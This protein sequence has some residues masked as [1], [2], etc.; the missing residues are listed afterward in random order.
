[1]KIMHWAVFLSILAMIIAGCGCT[2]TAPAQNTP[3]PAP[4][5]TTPV[6]SPPVPQPTLYPGAL[7][8]GTSVPF[9]IN[10]MNG[11]ATVYRAEVRSEYTYTT[12]TFNSPAEQPE[13][14]QPLGT[15][16]GYNTETPT[17]GKRFAVIFVRLED[18]GRDRL[19]VPSPWAF[20]MSYG[21]TTYQYHSVDGPEVITGD[22][23]GSQYDYQIGD[24][25]VAGSILPGASNAADGF[26]IYEVPAGID[27]ARAAMVITLDPAHTGVWK[28]A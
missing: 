27:L 12:S 15:Q 8:L 10:G 16:Y 21:G 25:G 4:V 2:G 1:M 28:L 9:G 14:G 26:L 23:P 20:V 19:A 22:I 5:A 11:T 7:P 18:T 13:A 24:G 17:P 6:P 3:V